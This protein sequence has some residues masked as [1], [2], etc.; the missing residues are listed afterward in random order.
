MGTKKIIPCMDII[1]GREVKG[2]NFE[3]IR[4]AAD[5]VEMAELYCERGAD[6]LVFYDITASV[7]GK[8]PFSEVLDRV[9]AKATVP[10][11]IGGGV[12]TIEDCERAFACGAAKLSINSGAINNPEFLAEAAKKYGKERMILSMD[13]KR[14]D[15]KFMVFTSAGREN[16]GLLA[17]EWVKKCEALGAG[18]IVANSID[19]DGV[20]NGYDIE[21]LE[22]I[23][24]VVSIP[25]IAS[26]G[27]GKKEDFL[28]L[29]KKTD[30]AAGLAASVF[31]FREIDIRELKEYLKG[32]GIDVKL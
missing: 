19:T 14:V 8:K 11:I 12:S 9:A 26:G 27:A 18:E 30:V 2:V 20:K 25:V 4:D 15:G 17:L 3:G 13:V 31:H 22:A 23:L 7:R 5:P 32:E 28:E 16:T 24:N 1:D 21:M 10:F 29:F 6:E